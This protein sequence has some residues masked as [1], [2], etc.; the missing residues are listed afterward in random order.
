MLLEIKNLSKEYKRN[1]RAFYALDNIKLN[2]SDGQ[3]I[4]IVGCSGSGKSTL[5]SV[6][7]GLQN[8]AKGDVIIDGQSICG[9]SDSEIS[10]IR[11][12]KI[13]YIPQGQS[14]LS[15]LTVLDNVCL[16]HSFTKQNNDVEAK[17]T[18]LLKQL[19]INELADSYPKSLSGGERRRA[20]IARALVN[21]PKI[22]LADEPTSDLDRENTE[23]VIRIFKDIAAKGTTVLMATHDL[24]AA[25]SSDF[26]YEICGGKLETF[27]K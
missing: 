12:T 20:V 13:G 23:E 6:I 22:I 4:S 8:P 14:L 24:S 10:Y 15:N 11:S 18:D 19:G 17:A 21:E 25:N 3:F 1:G 16:P 9:L 26:V 2:A 27:D 5:L 7:A